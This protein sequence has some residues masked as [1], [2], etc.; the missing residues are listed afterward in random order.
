M[1]GRYGT[2]LIAA[3]S[4]MDRSVM[5]V[6]VMLLGSREDAARRCSMTEMTCQASSEIVLDTSVL[7][8]DIVQ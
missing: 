4:S 7:G 2:L 1:V 3:K 6:E 8:L 5:M